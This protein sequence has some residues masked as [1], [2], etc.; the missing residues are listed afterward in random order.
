LESLPYGEPSCRNSEET[1]DSRLAR[2]GEFF[3]EDAP[4]LTPREKFVISRRYHLN[5]VDHGT[6][7]LEQVGRDRS[8]S[9]ERVRQVQNVALLKLREA[10]T[11][12]LPV[13]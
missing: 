3:R 4:L 8:L 5:D 7:T 6:E 9:K 2:L 13:S 12:A 10:L 11:S 1:S